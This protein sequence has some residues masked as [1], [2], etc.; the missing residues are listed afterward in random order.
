MKGPDLQRN[1]RLE[2]AGLATGAGGVFTTNLTF[3]EDGIAAIRGHEWALR[4]RGKPG[5]KLSFEAM[6][7]TRVAMDLV[8]IVPNKRERELLIDL[9]EQ[10]KPMGATFAQLGRLRPSP[11]QENAW[12]L[13]D[14]EVL[15]DEEPTE[16]S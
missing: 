12:T 9:A 6:P 14:A 13:D 15:W 16:P 10:A 8:R 7:L 1:V 2:E 5:G 3:K 4:M 11:T